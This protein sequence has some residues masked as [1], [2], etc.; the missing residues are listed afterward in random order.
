[1][2]SGHDGELL[3]SDDEA[4]VAAGETTSVGDAVAVGEV[5]L[6]DGDA[7]DVGVG[8]ALGDGVPV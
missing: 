1:M 2:M 8:D 7:E 4:G 5:A 3:E 6:A